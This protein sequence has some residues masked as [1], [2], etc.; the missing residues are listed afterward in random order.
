MILLEDL[1]SLAQKAERDAPW[2]TTEGPEGA[3]DIIKDVAGDADTIVGQEGFWSGDMAQDWHN[4]RFV[5]AACPRNLLPILEDLERR[6]QV[7]AE[8]IKQQIQ[9][10]L[11]DALLRD[12]TQNS[13]ISWPD[14]LRQMRTK[15]AG[16]HE[17]Q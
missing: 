4:A 10:E 8:T 15:L 13:A 12:H 5:A 1:I 16:K 3:P 6:R 11:I 17:D 9:L 7:D 2:R 14:H